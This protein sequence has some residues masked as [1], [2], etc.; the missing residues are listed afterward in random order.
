MRILDAGC[1][2]DRVYVDFP[3]DAF[4]TGIDVDADALALN[5]DLDEKIVG[6]IQTYPLEPSGYDAIV[7]WDVLEHLPSPQ[8]ALERMTR[9]LKPGGTLILGLPNVVSPKGL[10]TKL[11]PHSFHVWFYRHVFED[12]NAGTPGY[13]PYKTYLRWSLRPAAL[14]RFAAEQ[15]LTVTRFELTGSAQFQQLA[16]RHRLASGLLRAV[17]PG[18]PF[19]SECRVELRRG[20]DEGESPARRGATIRSAGG[21]NRRRKARS[22]SS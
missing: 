1:G 15:G 14:R 10:A 2:R 17:W 19:L 22:A 18:D 3:A 12:E 9:A 7:C 11:T 5:P 4:V 20:L 8:A 6:D 21:H 13:G 16:D